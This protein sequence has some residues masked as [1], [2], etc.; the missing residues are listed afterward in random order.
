MKLRIYGV[1]CA[2]CEMLEK[3]VKEAI[4]DLGID[5]KIEKIEDM[6]AILESGITAL[7]ALAIDGKIKIMGRVASKEEIKNLLS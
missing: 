2:N 1:G 3:N 5:A 4:N 6:D 7:P